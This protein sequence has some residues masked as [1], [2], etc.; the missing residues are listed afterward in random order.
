MEIKLSFL[1]RYGTG[2]VFTLLLCLCTLSAF[3]KYPETIT[4]RARLTGTNAPKPVTAH[5]TGKLMNLMK[6]NGSL[7][8]SNEVLGCMETTASM[9]E[10]L[11]LGVII[12]SVCAALDVGSNGKIIGYMQKKFLNL[13]ELQNAYQIFTQ[14][15]IPFRD[16]AV[17]GY[18]DQKRALLQK[19]L[20]ALTE[21]QNALQ[22][23]GGIYRQNVALSKMRLD[24][25]EKLLKEKVISAQEYRNFSSEHLEKQT[26]LPQVKTTILATKVQQIDKQKEILELENLA[27]SQLVLFREAAYN[28]KSEIEIWKKSYL[29]ISPIAGTLSYSTFLQENQQVEEGKTLGFIIPSNS[30]FYLQ[31]TID[32]NNFGRVSEGQPVILKFPSYQWQEFGTVVGNIEYISPTTSDSTYLAKIGIPHGLKTSM[33]KQIN[34]QDGLV[35][36]AEIITKDVS[37]LNRFL[38]TVTNIRGR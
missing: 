22:E 35:A 1:I 34:Y 28:F 38:F 6:A 10:V 5:M 23:Q 11:K 16:Y 27:K 30:Q 2:L 4:V 7:V 12:D 17:G 15:F 32:Q 20:A 21:S 8:K 14:A 31:A 19:D 36:N 26:S 24:M 25:S 33:G 18:I 29:L 9:E 37:L 13:G 3:I